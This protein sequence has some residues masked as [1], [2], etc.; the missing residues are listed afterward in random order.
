MSMMKKLKTGVPGFDVLSMVASRWAA[1]R[2][3]SAGAVR[4]RRFGLQTAC[5][6]ARNG[7]KS[8]VIGIEGAPK[9]SW[10]P[11]TRSASISM[12]CAPKRTDRR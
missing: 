3:S 11:A 7:I 10:P 4:A 12:R 6:L 1:P 2:W 8:I 9:T 5:H